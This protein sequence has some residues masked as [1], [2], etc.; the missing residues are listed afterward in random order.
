ML[1][2]V[3]N[4]I[5]M[6]TSW[7]VVATHLNLGRVLLERAGLMLGISGSITFS[8]LTF[9]LALWFVL[10]LGVLEKYTRFLYTPY[11]VFSVALSGISVQNFDAESPTQIYI[12]MLLITSLAMLA[13]KILLAIRNQNKDPAFPLCKEKMETET[14]I[15]YT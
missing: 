7:L 2:L 12:V 3:T 9:L 6:Y 14:V 1:G 11:I 5:G 8:L 15:A 4:G 13:L 10:D